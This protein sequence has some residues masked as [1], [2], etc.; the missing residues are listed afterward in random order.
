MCF[1]PLVAA[2]IMAA[3]AG[4]KYFGEKKA[5]KASIRTFNAERARQ[6]GFEDE[7]HGRFEDSLAST[8]KVFDPAEQA[9]AADARN[10]ALIAA[11]KSADPGA[12]GY[13]PGSSSAPAV[14]AAAAE[15][16]GAAAN[17][18][19]AGLARALATLGG[20][21][22]QLQQNDIRIGRNG[23]IIG[24]LGGFKRGSLG[25]LQSELDA[26]K[27]KGRTLRTLGGLAQSIGQMA[28]MGGGGAP[29]GATQAWKGVDFG[30]YPA[31]G[32]V[33]L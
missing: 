2:A 23:Q 27:Q 29:A 24:Q 32:A 19:T 10:A 20:L 3:G 5:E 17:S 6:R 11:T 26:A 30:L 31:R 14:V 25:V 16:A 13:L 4:M 33:G 21:T 18:R 15:N 1:P 12:E 22:D 28:L 9:A 8:R 7:Q